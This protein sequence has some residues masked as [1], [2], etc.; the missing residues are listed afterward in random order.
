MAP[1]KPLPLLRTSERTVYKRCP[2][3]WYQSVVRGLVP[4]NPR[5]DAR[6]FGT[7]I[8][9]CKAEWYVPGRKRGRDMHETWDEF[10]QGT[11]TTVSSQGLV[12]D[13]WE[14]E[15]VDANKLAHA[16]IDT[17][18]QAYGNDDNWEVIAAEHPFS[19]LIP[20][21]DK[22]IN[23]AVCRYVGT[24][25]LIIR[26]LD[27]GEIWLDDT[28]TAARIYTHH[29]TLLEQPAAYVAVGTH[30][31]REQGMIGPKERVKGI[32]F[33]FMRKG[34]PDERPRN[35]RGEYCNKPVKKHFV[36]AILNCPGYQG[37]LNTERD[38]LRLKLDELQHIADELNLTVLGDVSAN[39]GAPLL[40][41]E[42]ILKSPKE[43]S[44]Q[45]RRIGEEVLHMNA[46]RAGK[47]PILKT[48][49]DDC[50]FCDYFDLCELDESGGDTEYFE[51]QAFV[52]RDAYADHREGAE[53]SKI[54]VKNKNKTGVR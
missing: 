51:S 32:I 39:Q 14:S 33:D 21:P 29:L 53:N 4:N 10:S 5:Q 35:E 45:I 7:G 27:T 13:E 12:N 37:P 1:R 47:L 23:R 20:H 52:V 8:H 42:K 11:F 48:P 46:V 3:K 19:V 50:N 44:R 43:C 15:W 30:V 38:L 17:H 24:I 49:Q 36:E 16:M 22:T 28:K 26:E 40:L 18:L 2:W 34:F 9:L 25:D 54:S 31:L 41:R 6:W